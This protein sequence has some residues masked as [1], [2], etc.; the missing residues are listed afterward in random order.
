MLHPGRNEVPP[1]DYSRN[2]TIYRC[3]RQDLAGFES[4][5]SIDPGG[6][7]PLLSFIPTFNLKS[8][9]IEAGK[10]VLQILTRQFSTA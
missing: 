2:W 9:N 10:P 8:P 4:Q 6:M 7:Q 3:F 1:E 5:N